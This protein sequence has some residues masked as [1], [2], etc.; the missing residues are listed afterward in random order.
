MS[1]TLFPTQ[2]LAH[3]DRDRAFVCCLG[4]DIAKGM[5][6]L[7]PDRFGRKDFKMTF[8]MERRAVR[9]RNTGVFLHPPSLGAFV[10]FLQQVLTFLEQ[11]KPHDWTLEL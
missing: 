1:N 5:L 3:A 10:L 2:N 8:D 6:G 11:W 7:P 4:M 9:T